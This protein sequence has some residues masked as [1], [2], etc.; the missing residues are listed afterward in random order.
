MKITIKNL[1]K[2][3]RADIQLL[4]AVVKE[5]GASSE[6]GLRA[7]NEL[8]SKEMLMWYLEDEKQFNRYAKSVGVEDEGN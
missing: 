8:A 3:V 2:V 5:H 6:L 7:I 1:K 4:R